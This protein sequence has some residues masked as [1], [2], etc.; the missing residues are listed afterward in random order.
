M[1]NNEEKKYLL[2]IKRNNN[3]Y[4]PLEWHF[5]SYYND[6][7]LSTLEGIDKFTSQLTR[8]DL[9]AEVLNLNMI[10]GNEKFIDFSIIYYEK[11]KTREVKEGTIFLEDEIDLNPDHF[12]KC[13]ADNNEN[14]NLLNQV[15]NACHS[16]K[17]EVALSEFKFILKN[18]NYFINEGPK[19][20][21]AALSLFAKISYKE[22]R[23][24]ILK[25]AKKMANNKNQKNNQLL[26]KESFSYEGKVA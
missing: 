2:V 22:R 18:I 21:Y 14:K 7:N 3:D 4:L 24:I 23:N 13:L 6:E 11:G 25:F 16:K 15:Y 20:V 10:D 9:L 26:K 1:P 5:T 12:A 19:A 17:E 8:I